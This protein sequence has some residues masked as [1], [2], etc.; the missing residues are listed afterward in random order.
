MHLVSRVDQRVRVDGRTF[1]FAAG[2][3]ICT[4]HSHKY[5]L[6]DFAELAAEAGLAVERVWTDPERLFSVQYLEAR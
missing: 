6:A 2:E 5:R 4:E 1:S 3:S